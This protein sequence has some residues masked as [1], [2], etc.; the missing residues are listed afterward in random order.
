MNERILVGDIGGTH[1]R[2][3]LAD[4]AL[5]LSD[6]R[7]YPSNDF[8]DAA[9]LVERYR[10]DI[11]VAEMA[12]CC[13]AI[14]GP[15]ID[16]RGKLTNGR[17]SCDARDLGVVLGRDRAL[18][19]NDFTAVG[20]AL[21]VLPATS[22]KTIGPEID[23]I[24]TKAALGP[25][26]GL[27][28]GFV[29]RHGGRWLVLPSEGG[30]ANLAATD[31]LEAEVLGFLLRGFDFVGWE[32]VL[33]GPGLVNLYRAVCEVWGTA[34]EVDQPNL[35]T[36]RALTVEDPVCHQTLE[37]F[38]NLLGTAAGGLAVTVCAT[39]GVYVAGGIL[40][41]LGDFFER[42]QF[43]RR[44]EQRGPMSDYVKAIPTRLVLE[45]ELGLVGSAAAYWDAFPEPASVVTR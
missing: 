41:K 38:C 22:L 15:V 3:A 14:A 5:A 26:T 37:M 36:Q 32:T 42:S 40:P 27:G 24:G 16:G 18:V 35:I 10:H 17:I 2:L 4:P 19:I 9:R 25:G 34:P 23:A 7:D 21:P 1:A 31:P 13:L 45:P 12:G 29:V 43:R 44:F 33:S 30:H 6:V 11:G 20:H 39:G 28:M 8:E